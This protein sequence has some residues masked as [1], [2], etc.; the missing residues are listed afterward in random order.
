MTSLGLPMPRF[1]AQVMQAVTP[2]VAV[3]TWAEFS[4]RLPSHQV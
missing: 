1:A 2:Q 3:E 4:S